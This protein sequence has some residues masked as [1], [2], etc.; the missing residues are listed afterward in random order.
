MHQHQYSL[1]LI[2]HEVNDSVIKQRSDDGYINAT[3]LC[4]AANK[5]FKDYMANKS[6]M[7]FLDE[8]SAE[9]GLQ[10][11]LGEK[12]LVKKKQALIET[13]AGAPMTGGGSWVHPQVAIHLG[14]WASGKFAV[15]VSKWVHDWMSGKGSPGSVALLP[16]HLNR[17]IKNDAN[18]PQ[19]YFSILQETGLSLFGPLHNLGFE[20]PKGWVPD[21]SVG[22]K[23][24]EWLRDKHGIDTNAL[25]TYSHDYLDGRPIV[26]P[27]VYPD[28][29][30][31]EF[32][33]WF[34]E[35]WLPAHGVRYFKQ[36]DP[37]S[38]AFLDKLPALAAPKKAA[39][40]PHFKNPA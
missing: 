29:F 21:I 1:A 8:L 10:I 25:P 16:H 20:I 34:R 3:E 22:L 30:L 4:K 11:Q 39:N 31:A 27:K 12:S 9:T 35:I 40:I 24:C 7:E 5:S 28:E 2:Q 26:Y 33:R 17:Y 14:Q 37:S 32:R 18:V 23:F 6:T 36:K 13:F 15:Q 38:L 19:G